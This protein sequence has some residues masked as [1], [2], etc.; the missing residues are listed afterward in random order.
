MTNYDIYE[1]NKIEEKKEIIEM[2]L[3]LKNGELTR[4]DELEILG[5]FIIN[6]CISNP[7]EKIIAKSMLLSNK[8]IAEIIANDKCIY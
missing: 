5:Q 7:D 1:K 6:I 4:F 8:K 2:L 3:K